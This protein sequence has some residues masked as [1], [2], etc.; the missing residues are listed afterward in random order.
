MNRKQ[1]FEQEIKAIMDQ[2]VYDCSI[3]EAG[4]KVKRCNQC[5]QNMG[6]IIGHEILC[7]KELQKD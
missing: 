6:I 3:D 7:L 2:A 1:D 4:H 5:M